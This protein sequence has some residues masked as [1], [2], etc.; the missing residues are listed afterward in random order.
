MASSLELIKAQLFWDVPPSTLLKKHDYEMAVF[1]TPLNDDGQEFK[2][3]K[4]H[5]FVSIRFDE[6]SVQRWLHYAQWSF[7]LKQTTVHA[8]NLVLHKR[9]TKISSEEKH[10]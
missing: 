2:A 7:I 9:L 10:N 5:F 4:K 3:H 6:P 8:E 1:L